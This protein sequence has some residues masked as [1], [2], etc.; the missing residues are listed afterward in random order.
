MPNNIILKKSSTSDKVPLPGDLQYG[1]LALNF[2]DG[3]LFYKNTSNA[4]TTIASNKFVSVTGN[5]T[6]VGNIQG[7]Y[8]IGNGSLLTGITGG[9]GAGGTFPVI[10]RS[11]A[12]TV[13]V[14]SGF[15]NV[16]TRNSGTRQVAVA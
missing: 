8:F 9:G 5:I 10:A 4:I 7:N 2:A 6:A 15:F 1:E 13:S 3:N 12:I 14:V 11:G 16:V